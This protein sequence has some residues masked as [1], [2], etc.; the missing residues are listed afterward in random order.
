MT[1]KLLEVALLQANLQVKFVVYRSSPQ[2]GPFAGTIVHLFNSVGGACT[3]RSGKHSCS[4]HGQREAGLEG[5][6]DYGVSGEVMGR[7]RL[8]LRQRGSSTCTVALMRAGGL[9]VDLSS[10]RKH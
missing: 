2:S 6:H 9:F 1:L 5:H 8:Y 7:A 4:C 10:A 3:E